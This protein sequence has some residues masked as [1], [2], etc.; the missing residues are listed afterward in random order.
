MAS[1][2]RMVLGGKENIREML[3]AAG[4][5]EYSAILSLPYVYFMPRTCDPHAQ[6]VMQL[7][8]GLQNLMRARKQGVPL[9]GYL[10]QSTA[11]ALERFSGPNW[12]DKTWFQIYGDVIRGQRAPGYQVGMQPI[13][14]DIP[15]R[16][17]DAQV[18]TGGLT[19]AVSGVAGNP[20]AWLAAGAGLFYYFGIKRP[21]Y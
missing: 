5:G 16:A 7:V 2:N 13:P 21:R 12:R 19:D 17:A 15:D 11:K 6:G 9:D 4:I 3:L 18:P 1:L 14:S 20:L 10:G 8:E